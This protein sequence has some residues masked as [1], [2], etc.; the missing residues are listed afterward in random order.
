MQVVI[1]LICQD[2]EELLARADGTAP[3]GRGGAQRDQPD[4][5]W[6]TAAVEY[7]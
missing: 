4:D 3:V 6:A 1:A 7:G 2:A 5:G